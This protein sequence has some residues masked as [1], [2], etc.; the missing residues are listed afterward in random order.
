MGAGRPWVHRYVQAGQEPHHDLGV[1]LLSDGP[2]ANPEAAGRTR[3]AD[4]QPTGTGLQ[5]PKE[6]F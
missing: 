4:P 5:D 3:G 2:D 1:G 6:F